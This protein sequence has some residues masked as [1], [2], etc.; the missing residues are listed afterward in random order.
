[1][2][3][4]ASDYEQEFHEVWPENWAVFRLFSDLRTQW[5]SGPG[6]V[7]GLDH[8]VLYRELDRR[9]LSPHEYDD[10]LVDFRTLEAAAL[11]EIYKDE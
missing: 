9:G 7:I 10:L 3:L 1:M 11:D 8:N 2:G 6:G 5:R 4:K